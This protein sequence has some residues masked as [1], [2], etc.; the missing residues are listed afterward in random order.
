M[1][2][3][4]TQ[5]SRDHIYMRV[6]PRPKSLAEHQM[7]I[8]PHDKRPSLQFLSF[9]SKHRACKH[10]LQLVGFLPLA[11]EGEGAQG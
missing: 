1:F 5:V 3:F 6:R 2:A 11:T 4:V 8:L 9:L 7:L 10:M